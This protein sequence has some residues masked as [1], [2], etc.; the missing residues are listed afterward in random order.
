MTSSAGPMSIY[1]H[2]G[3]NFQQRKDSI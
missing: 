3:V 1:K 2:Q